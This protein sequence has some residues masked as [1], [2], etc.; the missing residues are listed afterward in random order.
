[1]PKTEESIAIIARLTTETGGYPSAWIGIT[2][3][4]REDT[5]KFVDDSYVLI[6]NWYGD[7]PWQAGNC[8][9]AHGNNRGEWLDDQCYRSYRIICQRQKS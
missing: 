7:N 3:E 4:E 5:F 6:Y 2:D 9:F 8:L 1:M